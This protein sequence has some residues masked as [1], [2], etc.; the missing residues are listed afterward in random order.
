MTST[1]ARAGPD[2]RPWDDLYDFLDPGRPGNTGPDRDGVAEARCL[3]IRRRLTCYFSA[4]GCAEADDLAIETL[5]RVAG[6]CRDVDGSGFADR[7]GYFYG[8]ARN[9]LHE[10]QRRASADEQGRSSFRAELMRVPVPDAREWARKER[11]H[12]YLAL[13]LATL[14]ERARQLV[15]DYYRGEPGTKVEHHKALAAESGKSVNSLRIEVHRIRKVV[16]DC[17]FKRL[18]GEV[19]AAASASGR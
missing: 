12:R 2:A 15:L 5:L 17:L 3:E 4:G 8:V 19:S 13:C 1:A 14:T 9:V 18:Q 10:W 7:T 16:R 6:K 11:V